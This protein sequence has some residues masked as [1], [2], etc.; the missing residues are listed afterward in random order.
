MALESWLRRKDLPLDTQMSD[1]Q[2]MAF[3]RAMKDAYDTE[4]LQKTLI[5]P[6]ACSPVACSPVACSPVVCSTLR[7][8]LRNFPDPQGSFP[9]IQGTFSVRVLCWDIFFNVDCQA[10]QF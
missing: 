7:D 3:V 5:A 1:P 6:V 2:R 4:N 10:E 9:R 8:V